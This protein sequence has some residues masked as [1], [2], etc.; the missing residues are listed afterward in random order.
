MSLNSS[1]QRRVSVRL[2]SEQ[3]PTTTVAIAVAVVLGGHQQPGQQPLDHAGQLGTA[4]QGPQQTHHVLS[5]G[6]GPRRHVL[7]GH[8]Q[9]PGRT[10]GRDA[11]K[12]TAFEHMYSIARLPTPCMLKQPSESLR[13]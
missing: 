1:H 12:H 7:D 11:R 9:R 4:G 6:H 5:A 10:T 2:T 8:D 3:A 13:P